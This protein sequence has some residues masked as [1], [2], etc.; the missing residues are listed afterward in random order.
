[1]AAQLSSKPARILGVGSGTGWLENGLLEHGEVWGTDLS[2]SAIAE[3]RSRYPGV[4]L[5]CCDFLAFEFPDPFD[6]VVSADALVPMQNHAACLDRMANLLRP[7]GMLVLM[8]QNP[9]VW[10]PRSRF[11]KVTECIPHARP[12]EWP[13]KSEI[14]Q[15]LSGR[16]MIEREFTFDPGGDTGLLWW[17]ENPRVQAA[18]A[19]I[20]GEWRWRRVLEHLGLG[21]ELVFI[22][23]KIG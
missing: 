22:A 3:G 15:W 9:L 19:R 23:R 2:P 6:M 1:V 18:M 17:V 5:Q 20:I 16:F 13:Q 8:T 4:R 7:G 10:T 11:E 21:R 12:Q 14:R